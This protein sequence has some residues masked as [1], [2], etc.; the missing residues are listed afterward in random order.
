M[1]SRSERL[2]IK[3]PPT[4][5]RLPLYCGKLRIWS[6]SKAQKEQGG[7]ANGR[8]RSV[9]LLQEALARNPPY[10][11]VFS[12]PPACMSLP[13]RGYEEIF[14][15]DAIRL[16]RRDGPRTWRNGI[17]VEALVPHAGRHRLVARRD[18]AMPTSV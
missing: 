3:L 13:P 4:L 9:A 5:K 10:I 1:V 6:R 7:Y 16:F 14:H 8:M 17:V 11:V 15:E 2:L 18:A 12:Q